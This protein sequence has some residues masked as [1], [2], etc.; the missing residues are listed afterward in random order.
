MTKTLETLLGI[1]I[2]D[3]VLQGVLD[4]D[5]HVP[6]FIPCLDRVYLILDHVTVEI[7]RDRETVRLSVRDVPELPIVVPPE[8][9]WIACRSSVG[10]YVL[11]DPLADTR[12]SE[13]IA[14]GCEGHAYQA[15]EFRFISGQLLFFDPSFF[16]GINL[17]GSRRF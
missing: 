14:Y 4:T 11:V 17:G 1:E 5:E 16:D 13:I 15:L 7:S 2:K 10:N 12:I 3:V 8:E 6:E 9:G